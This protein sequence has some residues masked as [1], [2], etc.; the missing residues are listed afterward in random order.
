M[1][2]KRIYHIC[3]KEEWQAAQASGF[4]PGSSQDK[5]DGFIHF[6]TALLIFSAIG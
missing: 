1:E 3:R 5:A 6:S 4:Y 2:N